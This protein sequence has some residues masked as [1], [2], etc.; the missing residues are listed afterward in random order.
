MKRRKTRRPK[1]R[2]KKLVPTLRRLLA[3]H[4]E[5]AVYLL[6]SHCYFGDRLHGNGETIRWAKEPNS[7]M[8]PQ[9]EAAR[10]IYAA[11]AKKIVMYPI[12]PFGAPPPA[13]TAL[14]RRNH[15]LI[16]DAMKMPEPKR[17]RR[18]KPNSRQRR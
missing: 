10:I 17:V 2:V 12:A 6:T 3:K 13:P 8:V 11:W 9:N 1:R 4:G 15:F 14:Q 16:L 18:G 7:A 5:R